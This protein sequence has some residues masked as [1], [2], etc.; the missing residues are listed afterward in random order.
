MAGWK[1]EM[2]IPSEDKWHGNGLVFA[3]EQEALDWGR[4]L[5]MRWFVPTDS[6]AVPTDEEPNYTLLPNGQIATVGGDIVKGAS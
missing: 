3:T 5:L 1:P 4:G 6:R 2:Y